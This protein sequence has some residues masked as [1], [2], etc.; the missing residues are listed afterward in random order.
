MRGDWAFE[1]ALS[2][3]DIYKDRT[4]KPT[5]ALPAAANGGNGQVQLLGGT[6]WQT[7]DA[8]ADWRPDAGKLGHEVAFGYHYDQHVLEDRTYSNTNWLAGDPSTLSSGNTGKTET[9]ALYLQD[10]LRL[11][12]DGTLT[13]GVRYEQWRAFDGTVTSGATTLSHVTREEDYWSPK[14]SLSWAVSDDWLLRGSLSRAA[15]FP[16]VTELFQGS[17]SGTSI[18]N[19]DPNLKP[20]QILTGELAAERNIESGSIRVSLFQ[21]N[22]KDALTRQTNTT[23]TPNVTNIQN[24]DEARVRGIETSFQRRDAFFNGLD[25]M[26]S[27]TFA[28]SEILANSNNPASVGK[29]MLRI[30]DWRATLAATWHLN[31]KMDWTLAGRYSGRQYNTLDNSDTNDGVYGGVSRF[32]VLD[33][34]FNYRFD[35][36]FSLSAGVDNL[37]NEKYYAAHPY[38]QRTGV[39]Q[40][41][42]Q[43]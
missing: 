37:T 31:D 26:G 19:N 15:R 16:T 1:L 13:L 10:S 29:H 40:V 23:V 17:V 14:A 12:T 30:P 2:D 34:K 20:E 8:R 6:G 7:V 25:L 35:K 11:F 4:R 38:P 43:Y 36:N 42:Y 33:T 41:K 24:V 21:D 27:L 9:Q 18:V 28:D 39:A 22:L 32:F 5:V 3:Y